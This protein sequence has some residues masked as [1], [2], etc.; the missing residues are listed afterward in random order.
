M[1]PHHP[2]GNS[3]KER[4]SKWASSGIPVAPYGLRKALS[5][6]ELVR[7]IQT[8]RLSGDP[9][10]TPHANRWIHEMLVALAIGITSSAVASQFE[11][12]SPLKVI[13]NGQGF[14]VE[15]FSVDSL[16]FESRLFPSPEI[17]PNSWLI[18]TSSEQPPI[19]LRFRDAPQLRIGSPLLGEDVKPPETGS[20]HVAVDFSEEM[21]AKRR[22]LLSRFGVLAPEWSDDLR[23]SKQR[24]S[25]L[26]PRGP[27]GDPSTTVLRIS[28][29]SPP[30]QKPIPLRLEGNG[31]RG[32]KTSLSEKH[33]LELN[34]RWL[35]FSHFDSMDLS[36]TAKPLWP[37]QVGS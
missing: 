24:S 27:S 37:G 25:D 17:F 20:S 16:P 11:G 4:S 15:A 28:L 6:R 31:G 8:A 29:E 7:L 9:L 34:P 1:H 33:V 30:P 23:V 19:S 22:P 3:L 10:R 14:A 5:M 36:M 21:A 13:P 2:D 12:Q 26:S 18:L 35:D 32:A